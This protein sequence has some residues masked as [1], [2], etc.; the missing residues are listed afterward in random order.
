M[1]KLVIL[2]MFVLLFVVQITSGQTKSTIFKQASWEL[3]FTG[4]LGSI[5]SQSEYSSSYYYFRGSD[6]ESRTY[7]QLGIIPAYYLTDGLAIEP[8]INLLAVEKEEPALLLLGNLAYTVN[9]ENSRFYPFIRAGY[10]ITNS[11]QIPVN[12]NLSKISGDM[13]IGVL[14]LGAGIKTLLTENILLRTEINFRKFSYSDE[15]TGYKYSMNISS[16]ALIFGFS[17]LL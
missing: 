15:G 14:N 2:S 17:V 4:S 10:G 7:F 3:N 12:G 6:S 1:K 11:V 13:D 16:I 5:E 8:E 9:L